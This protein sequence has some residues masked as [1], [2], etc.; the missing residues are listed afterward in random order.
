MSPEVDAM[1]RMKAASSTNGAFEQMFLDAD[2]GGTGRSH[3]TTAAPDSEYMDDVDDFNDSGELE[4]YA[5]LDDDTFQDEEPDLFTAENKGED[6][7][8][9]HKK[10][11]PAFFERST[12]A[13]KRAAL[14]T[15]VEESSTFI[16]DEDNEFMHKAT[17]RA[18][19]T[20][21][22]WNRS[23]VKGEPLP[24]YHKKVSA[25]LDSDDELMMTM[26]EKGF[27]D[28]QISDKL[29]KDGR[30]RYDQK[31]IS[32]R[33]AR[34]RLAQADHVDYLLEEGYKEWQY[35]DDILLLQ[36]YELANIEINYEMEKIRAWRFRRV[37][38]YMRRLN[39]DALFSAKACTSR[40]RALMDG[41]ATIPSEVDDNP[42]QRLAEMEAFRFEREQ[43][44]EVERKEKEERAK[45]QRKIKEETRLR[46]AQKAEEAS[47]RQRDKAQARAEKAM[48]RAAQSAMK[49]EQAKQNEIAKKAVLEKIRATKLEQESKKARKH[50][51]KDK[52]VTLQAKG[53]EAT[54]ITANTPDPRLFLS[55]EDLRYHCAQRSL[56]TEGK[57]KS[58]LVQRLQD[59]DDQYSLIDIKNLCR[60]RGLNVAGTKTQ[61]KYNLAM[62]IAKKFASFDE[63]HGA[64]DDNGAEGAGEDGENAEDKVGLGSPID[65]CKGADDG[66][67]DVDME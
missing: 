23:A 50:K 8:P 67:E 20:F 25:D 60:S 17:S 36:A 51:Q 45:L 66:D 12:N 30:I 22:R 18:P 14:R 41:T 19:G 10:A 49:A 52:N 21:G 13:A 56:S 29:A 3:S 64:E 40:Y 2:L 62:A 27:S 31:S 28:K 59:A 57:G 43:L 24:A 58:D 7:G 5:D 61:L 16:L 53:S 48:K 42:D 38:E 47:T 32:T 54:T 35:D 6:M 37:S 44:R 4:G 55:I 46:N 65:L 26:R 9:P 33:I 63:N 1:A 11:R 39:A 34:I 15:R